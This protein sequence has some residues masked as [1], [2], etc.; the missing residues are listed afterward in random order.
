ME[1]LIFF[2]HLKGFA[3]W[4]FLIETVLEGNK[5]VVTQK[6]ELKDKKVNF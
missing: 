1:V 6:Q 4:R 2:Q 5:Q 3:C